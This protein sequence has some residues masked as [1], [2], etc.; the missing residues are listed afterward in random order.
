MKKNKNSV[1]EDDMR[2]EYHFDYSTAVRGKYYKRIQEEGS[3]TVILDSEG[4]EI[5][6]IVNRKPARPAK[7]ASTSNQ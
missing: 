2:P 1:E 5:E 3:Y 4:N 7:P 6:R